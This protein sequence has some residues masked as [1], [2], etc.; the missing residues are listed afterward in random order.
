LQGLCA[1]HGDFDHILVRGDDEVVAFQEARHDPP[2][3]SFVSPRELFIEIGRRLV[4]N[5][6]LFA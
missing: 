4:M 1:E 3:R 2:Q 5:V 6:E